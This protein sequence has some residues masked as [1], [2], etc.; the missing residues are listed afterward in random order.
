MNNRPVS[1]QFNKA[2][3]QLGNGG[4][5]IEREVRFGRFQNERFVPGVTK[6]QF[7]SILKLFSDWATTHKIDNIVSRTYTQKQ[8]IRK[9]SNSNG[10]NKFQLKEKLI[11]IDVPSEGVRLSKAKE[12]TF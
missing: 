3:D 1:R 7:E 12:T 5:N 11:I 10:T 9:I 2:L 4:Q 6:R 8:S